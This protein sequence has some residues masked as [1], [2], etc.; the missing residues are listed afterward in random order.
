MD[1]TDLCFTPATE[2]AG[3]IRAK[4]LSSIEITSTVLERITALEPKLNGFAHLAV[5]TMPGSG[6]PA[7]APTAS[8]GPASATL[9]PAEIKEWKFALQQVESAIRAEK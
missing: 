4:Q 8:T 5:R 3:A 2:L 9:P 7:A 6:T 1:K